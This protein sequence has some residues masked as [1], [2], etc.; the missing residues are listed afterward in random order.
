MGNFVG[1]LWIGVAV[2]SQIASLPAV[3]NIESIEGIEGGSFKLPP[4]IG[5]NE[6]IF[7]AL[8]VEDSLNTA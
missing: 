7:Q 5:H 3:E 8:A 4:S 1:K 6:P 2:V